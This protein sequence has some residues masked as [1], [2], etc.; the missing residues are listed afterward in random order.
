MEGQRLKLVYTSIHEILISEYEN[1]EQWGPKVIFDGP[2]LVENQLW[3][4]KLV[5]K[6]KGPDGKLWFHFG[7]IKQEV[8]PDELYELSVG[9]VTGTEGKDVFDL[10]VGHFDTAS[11][12]GGWYSLPMEYNGSVCELPKYSQQGAKSSVKIRVII[13]LFESH[14]KQ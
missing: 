3:D 11:G 10:G 14:R 5:P 2:I 9:F 1:A 7:I 8:L 12:K 4:V 6:L 13:K